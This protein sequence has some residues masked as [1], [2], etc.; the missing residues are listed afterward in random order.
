VTII[1]NPHGFRIVTIL[2]QE[3]SFNAAT[4]IDQNLMPLVAEFFPRGWNPD[5]RK[6]VVDIDNTPAHNSKN[7]TEFLR[8]CPT[9]KT[10]PSS[11]FI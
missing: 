9:Q 8:A 4:F 7:D 1:W 11:L 2:P 6:L 10:A 3:V 5:Q